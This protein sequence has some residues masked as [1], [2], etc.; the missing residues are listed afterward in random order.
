ME[1]RVRHPRRH[2][3]PAPRSE[4]AGTF[5]PFL[6]CMAKAAAGLVRQ[7]ISPLPFLATP[8]PCVTE[9][10]RESPGHG[11]VSPSGLVGV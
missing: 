6:P 4:G 11:L 5:R 8:S 10:L 9:S 7:R 2:S 3:D 1:P